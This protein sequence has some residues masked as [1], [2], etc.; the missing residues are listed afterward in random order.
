MTFPYP[1]PGPGLAL[2]Q[3][4]LA[5]RGIIRTTVVTVTL[6]GEPFFT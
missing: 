6:Q 3:T 1:I 2:L 4:E 5:P